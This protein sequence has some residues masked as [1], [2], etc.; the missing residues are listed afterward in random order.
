MKYLLSAL[1]VSL[2]ITISSVAVA[3]APK[4][5]GLDDSVVDYMGPEITNADLQ[6]Q[7]EWRE[8]LEVFA[9][10]LKKWWWNK[11]K[12]E[13]PIPYVVVNGEKVKLHKK[14]LDAYVVARDKGKLKGAWA[15][16]E[17]R[18]KEG[19]LLEVSG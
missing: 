4:F 5:P 6:E 11:N 13:K 12:K 16:V 1:A 3:D 18:L 14:F 7:R 8:K 9:R 17:K 19:F 2:L 10:E 15:T